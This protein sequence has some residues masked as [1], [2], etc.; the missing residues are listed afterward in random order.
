VLAS[1][2]FL[3]SAVL[4]WAWGYDG[5][6]VIDLLC[7]AGCVVMGGG[8]GL[9]EYGKCIMHCWVGLGLSKFVVLPLPVTLIH[10]SLSFSPSY[11]VPAHRQL[12]SDLLP[13]LAYPPNSFKNMWHGLNATSS[14]L[15]ID[16]K[17]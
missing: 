11:G 17:R 2:N 12:S 16:L 6:V 15:Q 8:V 3:L 9:G 4:L 1:C 14:S 5:F 10:L 7:W 13:L